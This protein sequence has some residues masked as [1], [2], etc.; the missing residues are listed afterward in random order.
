MDPDSI[1]L[2]KPQVPLKACS[3]P[4]D[5]TSSHSQGR[6]ACRLASCFIHRLFLLFEY[7]CATFLGFCVFIKFGQSNNFFNLR[8]ELRESRH[9]NAYVLKH[10]GFYS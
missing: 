5:H 2:V 9:C 7:D 10:A 1:T 8:Q 4:Q 3:G 6:L